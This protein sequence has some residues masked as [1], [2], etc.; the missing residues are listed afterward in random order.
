MQLNSGYL[1]QGG[2]YKIIKPLGQGGFGITYLAEQT[3]MER[4]VCIKEFFMK[5]YCD[6][7]EA[8]NQVSLGATNNKAMM[9]KYQEK[10]LKEA[11][12]IARLDHPN[13]IRIYDVFTENNT[14]YYVMEY[15]EGNN[16]NEIVK[17]HGALPES[18][19]LGYIVPIGEGLEYVHAK[20]INH[21]DIKPGNILIRQTDNRPVLI[22]FGMSKQY[23][24]SGDQTSSTPLGIS[25]GY[26]PL[27]LY[28]SGG[29]SSF[30]PQT[31]VYELGA[32]LYRLVTGNVPPSASDIMNEG[33]PEMPAGISAA[34]K[35]AIEKAMEF[36]KKDRFASIKEFIDM[37]MD[38]SSTD[39]STIVKDSIQSQIVIEDDDDDV[40]TVLFE[41][42]REEKLPQKA[43]CPNCGFEVGIGKFCPQCG[44][45]LSVDRN[46]TNQI[47]TNKEKKN[48][49]IRQLEE[50]MVRV[51]GGKFKMGARSWFVSVRSSPN[52]TPQHE[53]TVDDFSLCKVLVT[54]SL[55]N[56]VMDRSNPSSE[57][58]DSFPVDN[59]SWEDAQEF[60]SKL[61]K[62]TGQNYRLPTEAEW[63]FAAR[64]RGLRE[65]SYSGDNDP[66]VVLWH[67]GNS[68]YKLHKVGEK[69]PNDIG[70][71]DMSGNVWEWCQDGYQKY[72]SSSEK[73]PCHIN[74]DIKVLRGGS[75]GSDVWQCRVTARASAPHDTIRRWVGFRLAK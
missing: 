67:R 29:V 12:M 62:M 7:D 34:T 68:N 9:E 13:I 72:S 26:A 30:S 55:W 69:Q 19:A 70:L 23:D 48:S 41:E 66:E 10:F 36:R 64:G 11:R 15:V 39:T 71:Y 8:T 17:E 61:N 49:V 42:P 51:H 52:E 37:V 25:A 47:D 43:V 5:E 3:L 2:K 57:K 22:D 46:D 35:T 53:V 74:P 31:D 1:L 56:M 63:E 24:E 27:E 33:L 73:N 14:A 40:S 38:G 59:V 16:L 75:V 32:T 21:L 4:K 65:Y 6:R 58:G 28:Q 18:E 54:Q 44:T 50:N 60:I 20:N 45:M